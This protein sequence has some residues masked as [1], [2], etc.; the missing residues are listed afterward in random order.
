MIP[1]GDGPVIDLA[2]APDGRTLLAVLSTG[3]L[4][5][6]DLTR[7]ELAPEPALAAVEARTGWRRDAAS[8]GLGG[9]P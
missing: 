2:V 6:F 7:L 5:R 4:L 9:P 3:R 8:P 1:A